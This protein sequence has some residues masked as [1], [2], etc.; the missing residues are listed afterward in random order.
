MVF[1]NGSQSDAI[2]RGVH[3][4]FEVLCAE[5]DPPQI[6]NLTL[7]TAQPDQTSRERVEI[8]TGSCGQG[9]HDAYINPLGFAFENFDGLGRL[10]TEDSGKPVDTS[11]AYPFTGGTRAFSGAPELMSIMADNDMAHRCYAKHLVEFSLQR[12]LSAADEPLIDELAQLSMNE[13]SIKDMIVELVKK[14]A[15][16]VR[17]GGL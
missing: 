8:S 14:P 5:L 6:A 13:A 3:L 17:G 10:R 1:G 4:N 16:R 9:C 11:S 2:H 7:V 15:F 12:D